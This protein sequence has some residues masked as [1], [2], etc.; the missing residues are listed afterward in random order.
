MG[1]K[2]WGQRLKA[3]RGDFTQRQFA[4]QIGVSLTSYVEYEKEA[5][6]PTLETLIRLQEVTGASLDW[7]AAGHSTEPNLNVQV[8][9]GVIEAI[10]LEVP[11]IDAKSRAKLVLLL[12]K[13]RMKAISSE[14]EVMVPAAGK[15][16][17]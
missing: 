11:D 4:A 16:A 12:Y 10:E 3:L 13:D 8:L 14:P 7:L 9:E 6:A 2:A 15:I 17:S 5:R 1:N